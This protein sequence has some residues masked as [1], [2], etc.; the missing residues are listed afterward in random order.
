MQFQPEATPRK[1]AFADWQI[2]L[3]GQRLLYE[4]VRPGLVNLLRAQQVDEDLVDDLQLIIEE[5]LVNVLKHGASEQ[6]PATIKLD[7]QLQANEIVLDVV[8]NSHAYNPLHGV[9]QPN[10]EVDFADRP[11]GGLGLYLVSA[12][13]DHIDY[14]YAHGR[15]N[16]HIRKFLVKP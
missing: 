9:S 3:N 7:V 16:L 1:P 12:L 10:L 15:N 4:D 14:N 2:S 5:V 11:V 8:D 13:A 6:T